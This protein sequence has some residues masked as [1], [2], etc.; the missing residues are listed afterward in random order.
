VTG[1]E[2]NQRVIIQRA[3]WIKEMLESL[4]D[5]PIQNLE[6]FIQS[7]H[8]AAAAESY[9]RRALEA[10]FDLGRHI[11]AK[12]FAQPVTGYKE[13]AL[14]L[15]KNNVLPKKEGDLMRKVAGYR[16]R[17]VH[18][19]QEI[20]PEELQDICAHHLNELE[21]LMNNLLEWVKRHNKE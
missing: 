5:L 21:L 20:T 6:D 4:R 19:Y 16:N 11:L 9:L 10:L 3:S 8:N 12:R 15:I 13:I 17:M 7:R 1:G 18:Y 14:G 2:I